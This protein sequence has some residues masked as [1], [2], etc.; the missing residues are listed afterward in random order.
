MILSACK[1]AVN[2]LWPICSS[3]YSKLP[4]NIE[5]MYLI[6]MAK[7]NDKIT[8]LYFN[9]PLLVYTITYQTIL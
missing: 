7:F 4:I 3:A 5:G 2:L 1:L 6:L 8:K 9:Y